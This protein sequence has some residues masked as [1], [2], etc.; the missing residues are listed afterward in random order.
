MKKLITHL[1]STL[2]QEDWPMKQYH[3]PKNKGK[4]LKMCEAERKIPLKDL[5]L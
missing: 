2:R 5:Q 3:E 1:G 4:Y